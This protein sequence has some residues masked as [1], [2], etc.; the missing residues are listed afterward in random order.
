VGAWAL[1]SPAAGALGAAGAATAPEGE[2]WTPAAGWIACG[3]ARH[4]GPVAVELAAVLGPEPLEPQ[5]AIAIVTS[6]R[7]VAGVRRRLI[8]RDTAMVCARIVADRP[9][10]R[11][12]P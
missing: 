7:T 5:P 10:I 4:T 1:T 11:A 6:T 2:A 9:L 8:K 3:R 12:G